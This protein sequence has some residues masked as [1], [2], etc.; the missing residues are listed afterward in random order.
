MQHRLQPYI[1]DAGDV[2][3]YLQPFP[4]EADRIRFTI[5]GIAAR[6]SDGREFPFNLRISELKGRE[7]TRQRLLGAAQLPPGSYSGFSLKV[8]EAY[9]RGEE[10]DAALMAP[11]IPV[12]IDFFFTVI[13]RKGLQISL[14]F[15]PAESLAGGFSFRPQFSL[16]VPPLPISSLAGFV[17]NYGSGF[18]TVFDKKSGQAAGVIATGGG[19]AGMAMNQQAGRAYAA[20]PDRDAIEVIDVHAGEVTDRI[21]LNPGDRPRELALAPDGRTLFAVNSG[22]NTVSAID[23]VALFETARIAVGNGPASLL[24]DRTGRR[25]YV[26]NSLSSTITVIDIANRAIITTI[27]TE[28]GP[29]RG[30]FNRSGDRLFVIH[31]WS[32]YISVVNT[33]TLAVEKRLSVGLGIKFIKV[34]DNSGWVY[35]AREREAAVGVYEQNSFVSVDF[36]PTGAAIGYLTIDGTEN[37]MLLLS[38]EL[39]RL[40]IMNLIGRRILSSIDVGDSPYAVM[41]TGER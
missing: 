39:Q 6:G 11:D 14:T 9:L 7:L 4:Q 36:L 12:R 23:P 3:L 19:P 34:D 16:H 24:I 40:L 2:V 20:L 29:L 22:S 21:L 8:K 30:Q 26:F 33:A 5:E 1:E 31:G 37:N 25:G 17:S 13:K 38:P 10:G 41:V 18:I 15:K 32:P 28:S 27:A 35:L